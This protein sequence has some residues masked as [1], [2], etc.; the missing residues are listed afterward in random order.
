MSVVLL[1]ITAAY[2]DMVFGLRVMG[3]SLR[4]R[5]E[6]QPH[7]IMN[8]FKPQ[9]NTILRQLKELEAFRSAE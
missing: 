6:R 5:M 3:A 9:R 8:W 1:T 2:D 7:E 4:S